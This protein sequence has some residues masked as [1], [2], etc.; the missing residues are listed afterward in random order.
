MGSIPPNRFS[1]VVTALLA[2]CNFMGL[3]SCRDI[4]GAGK[5][6][7]MLIWVE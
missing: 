3:L 6:K 2:L 4:T 5:F 7:D 1:T